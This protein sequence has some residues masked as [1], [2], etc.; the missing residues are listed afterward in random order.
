MLPPVDFEEIRSKLAEMDAPTSDEAV[1]AYCLYPKVFTDWV[2]RYNEFGD[3]SVLDTPTFFFG[4]TPGEVIKVEIEQGKVLIIKLDHISE[5]NAAG[6]RTV[7]FEFNGL[8]R[9]I[10]IK[11][12]NAKA[13]TVSRKKAEKGNMGEIGA[14]LSGSVVKV[15]VEKGQSVTKGTPL[16]VT[17]AMKMETT[18]SAPISGIIS[19]IHVAAGERVESGDCLMEISTQM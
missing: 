16:I 9:E 18:L 12:R 7:V 4:M 17:E 3:V 15:L 2:K 6:M 8:P 19:A 13:T 11:D 1:S 14:S 10:E 5:A